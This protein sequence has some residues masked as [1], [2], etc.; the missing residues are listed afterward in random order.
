M[1]EG[2]ITCL[3]FFLEFIYKGQ[4]VAFLRCLASFVLSSAGLESV[5]DSEAGDAQRL[6]RQPISQVSAPSS[7]GNRL[8]NKLLNKQHTR[9]LIKQLTRQR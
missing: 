7:R 5:L 6:D 9:Q 8:L 2:T 4:L 3:R 1:V